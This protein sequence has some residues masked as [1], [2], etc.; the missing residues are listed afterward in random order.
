MF[1]LYLIFPLQKVIKILVPP[2][3][4]LP[5]LHSRFCSQWKLLVRTL[6]E[7]LENQI[8]GPPPPPREVH[9]FGFPTIWFGSTTVIFTMSRTSYA[10]AYEN[11]SLASENLA[12]CL[13]FKNV[14]S[15]VLISTSKSHKDFSSTSKNYATKS[16]SRLCS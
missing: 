11:S 8:R 6:I 2:Q 14:F 3:N 1:S 9:S 7:L 16:H 5:K 10:I 15:L 12:T 13:I 4:S